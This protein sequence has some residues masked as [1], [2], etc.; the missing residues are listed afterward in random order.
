MCCKITALDHKWLPVMVTK[1][2]IH[3]SENVNYELCTQHGYLEGQFCRNQIYYAEYMT[4]EVVKIDPTIPNFRRNLSIAVANS[5]YN[6]M[7][8]GH[9]LL[10]WIRLLNT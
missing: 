1:I 8:G 5:L 4:A 3:D 7:G 9:I 10:V 2:I 6:E